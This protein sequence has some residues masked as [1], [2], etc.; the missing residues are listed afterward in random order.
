M[1][2]LVK[3]RTCGGKR[4]SEPTSPKRYIALAAE[5]GSEQLYFA[6]CHSQLAAPFVSFSRSE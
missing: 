1:V 2:T 4:K 3:R 6:S 5:V